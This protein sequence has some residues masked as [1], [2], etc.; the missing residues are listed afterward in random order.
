VSALKLSIE[1]VQMITETL[2]YKCIDRFAKI[3]LTL[4]KKSS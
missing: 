3:W 4:L 1:I 2:K